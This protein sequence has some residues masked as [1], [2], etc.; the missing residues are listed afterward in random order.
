M[1]RRMLGP[2]V[3]ATALAAIALVAVLAGAVAAQA[4][5]PPR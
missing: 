3:L 2:G 5:L 4:A 1:P